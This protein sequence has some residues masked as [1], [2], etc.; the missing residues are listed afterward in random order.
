MAHFALGARRLDGNRL[1]V[2]IVR[3]G[4]ALQL[5][6]ELVRKSVLHKNPRWELVLSFF[7]MSTGLDSNHSPPT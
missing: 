4:A 5:G 1:P 3:R 6:S 2:T 7:G